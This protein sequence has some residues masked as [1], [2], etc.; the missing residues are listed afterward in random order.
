MTKM[1]IRA[2][3]AGGANNETLGSGMTKPSVLRPD[4]GALS[5]LLVLDF[6]QAAVGPVA[7]SY[8][9]MLGATVIKVEQPGGDSVRQG[10]P[11]M[12]GTST[13][14]IG[15]NLTKYGVKLDLK[16]AQ[17]LADAKRLIAKAD[18]LIENF[19]SPQ[20]MERL[21]LAYDAVLATLNP[22]LVYVQSSAFGA[23]GPWT[24]MYSDEWMTECVGGLVSCTGAADGRGEFTRGSALLDWNGAMI[25][26]V[27]CM[28]ALLERDRSGRGMMVRTS[29]LGSSVFS[30][31]TRLAEFAVTGKPPRPRG[32]ASAY[33]VPDQAFRAQDGY[34]NVTA[35]SDP[36]WRRLCD[37]LGMPEL[38]ADER[39]ATSVKRADHHDALIPLLQER[40]AALP[41]QAWLERLRAADVPCGANPPRASLTEPQ[42]NHPQVIANGM[43]TRVDSA[44]GSVLTQAP[45][46]EFERTP[47]ALSRPSP[48]LGE[49][50]ALVLGSIDTWVPFRTVVPHQAPSGGCLQGVRV[51][52][53][54]SGVPGP[55][56]GMV[57]TQLGASVVR[58]EPEQGDWLAGIPPL[59]DGSGAVYR[60]LNQGKRT[61]VADLTT[62]AGKNAVQAEITL[63]DLV[64]LGH[65][66]HK[67][68]HLGLTHAQ[69]RAWNT[70]AQICHVSAWGRRGPESHAAAGEL[71]IQAI[72]GVP[73]YLGAGNEEP[74]RLGFD[75]ASVATGLAVVQGLLAALIRQRGGATET[76]AGQRIDVSMLHATIALNQWST[77]AESAPD[78]PVG[79][80]L[81]GQDWH[82]DHGFMTR[83]GPCLIGFRQKPLWRHFVIAVGRV[84]L[85]A[86]QEFQRFLLTHPQMIAR[87]LEPGLENW[88]MRALTRLVRDELGGTIVPMLD[89][90]AVAD[91]EQVKGLGMLGMT[92]EAHVRLPLATKA[93]LLGPA[94][95]A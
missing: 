32:S 45:H 75:V 5:G 85:L 38:G 20:I 41:V 11:T 46:W 47:A 1:R 91:H 8:L 59:V 22:R 77:V 39:F 67:L 50:N 4:P 28:A 13:T 34:I 53:I 33:V 31:L 3:K 70:S 89:L 92:R 18:I 10:T 82:C 61:V 16:S 93:A 83:D 65:R 6:G 88:S 21:G 52:E 12:R 74:V 57:L 25:N 24:G 42:L 29:Q 35:P 27:V 37:V 56:A 66:E 2:L 48:L 87:Q 49:H 30:G 84:D 62:T 86:D 43:L 9:G 72:A 90:A 23:Q 15:N 71:Q 7:A 69:L 68:D 78:R 95:H 60:M 17:G 64:I 40:F 51:L 36:S 63:A 19:R 94:G 26:T 73:R 55:L 54:A 76:G 44:Y 58:I 79:R 14:F 80:Q 81:E